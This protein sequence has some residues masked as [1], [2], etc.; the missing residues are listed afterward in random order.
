MRIVQTALG[1]INDRTG[2]ID[3]LR[4]LASHPVPPNTGWMYVFGRRC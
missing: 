4:P 2:L 1:W 3:R